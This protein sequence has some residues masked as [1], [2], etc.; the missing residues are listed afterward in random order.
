MIYIK[1]NAEIALM[2]EAG[3]IAGNALAMAKGIVAEGMTTRRIDSRIR[4]FI[5]SHGAKPSFLN[6]NGFPASACISVNNEVIHG[7]PD[8]R[9]LKNGDI[10]KIDLGAYYKGFHSDTAVTLPVGE[11]SE[12]AAN[13][14]K[15]TREAFFKGAEAAVIGNRIGDISAAVESHVKQFGYSVVEEYVGH[16]VGRNL[17]ED[18]SVPNYATRNRGWRLQSGM[19]LAIEPMI[20]IGS[21]YVETLKN[22]WTVVTKDSSLSAHYEHTIAVTEDG[23]IILTEPDGGCL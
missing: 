16:G 8:N 23:V 3:R 20:N 6:Y 14:I 22:G 18:P 21:K 4:E 7:I 1:S 15:V 11:V 13:L 19:T 2:R 5:L 17:H 10:I 12:E 9:V